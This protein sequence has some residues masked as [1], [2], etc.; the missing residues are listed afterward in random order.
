MEDCPGLYWYVCMEPQGFLEPSGRGQVTGEQAW[1][2]GQILK[3]EQEPQLRALGQ[4]VGQQEA[5]EGKH[6][7]SP[8]AD[9]VT[10]P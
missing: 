4:G 1:S 3:M 6:T 8:K 10:Q 5:G 9:S 2:Q 7:G